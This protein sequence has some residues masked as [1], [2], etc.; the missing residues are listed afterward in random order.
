MDHK[1]WCLHLCSP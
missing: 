1:H